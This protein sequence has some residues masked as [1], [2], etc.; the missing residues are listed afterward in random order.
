MR[1]VAAFA[2]LAS[3]TPALALVAALLCQPQA[4][5]ADLPT[6]GTLYKDPACGC[7]A[8]W[9]AY[10]RENGFEVEIVNTDD[11]ASIKQEYGIPA[12]YEGCHTFVIGGYAIEGHVP[13]AAILKLLT[14]Q[15]AIRAISL[16]GMPTGSPGMGGAKDG[17]FTV[18]AI[19]DGDP[20]VYYEE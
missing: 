11:L 6:S 2:R 1:L 13:V 12:D 16:P 10:M 5:A 18:Y 4:H 20:V 17:P 14:E 9:G 7:C 3:M 8:A 19:G 15:P